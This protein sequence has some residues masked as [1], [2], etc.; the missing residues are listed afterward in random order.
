MTLKKK[1]FAAIIASAVFFYLTAFYSL[2]LLSKIASF[3]RHSPMP[4]RDVL[5]DIVKSRSPSLLNDPCLN[6]SITLQGL[7]PA[8]YFINKASSVSKAKQVRRLLRNCGVP[9]SEILRV[10]AVTEVKSQDSAIQL[11]WR[12]QKSSQFTIY[13]IPILLSDDRRLTSREI[14][15]LL[16][17]L[18]AARMAYDSGHS[19]VVVFEDD[20]SFEYVH[21]WEKGWKVGMRQVLDSLNEEHKNGEWDICQLSMTLTNRVQL[22]RQVSHVL[23][24]LMKGK[25]IAPR[26]PVLHRNMWGATA[27]LLSRGGMKKLLDTFWPGGAKS[28]VPL[29][30]VMS[31][32]PPGAMLDFRRPNQPD[33]EYGTSYAL[34]DVL[35]FSHPLTSYFAIRPLFTYATETSSIHEGHLANQEQSKE[36]VSRLLY[37][38]DPDMRDRHWWSFRDTGAEKGTCGCNEFVQA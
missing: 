1:F 30:H 17:H 25:S 7:V 9:D 35:L 4:P 11:W 19:S 26:D 32:S 16:S 20:V 24:R 10:P 13:G 27:Y 15:V 12:E 5:E 31:S 37:L 8:W 23:P 6:G 28:S 34:A 14:A 21:M 2:S 18:R 22:I 33:R 29:T 36:V 3:K 38:E